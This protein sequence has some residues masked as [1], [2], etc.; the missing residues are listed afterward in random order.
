MKLH[1]K[2][3]LIE[4][5]SPKVWRSYDPQTLLQRIDKKVINFDIY[6]I[7]RYGTM[8]IN[9]WMYRQDEEHKHHKHR[10][11]RAYYEN[12]GATLSLHR[13]GQASDK[14]FKDVTAEEVRVDI[15]SNEKW[16]RQ[17]FGVSAI[18]NKVNWLHSDFRNSLE[19]DKIIWFNP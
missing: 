10:G 14:A 1:K 4:Y 13:Q 19:I 15:K 9:D 3:S 2:L 16:I 6:L 5:F 12:V 17:T 11:F 18:E 7:E 8:I